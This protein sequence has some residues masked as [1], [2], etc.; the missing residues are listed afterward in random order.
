MLP[1]DV[2]RMPSFLCL[3]LKCERRS[4]VLRPADLL[5]AIDR[6]WARSWACAV[7]SSAPWTHVIGLETPSFD[8]V[9]TSMQCV[10][11]RR[12]SRASASPAS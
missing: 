2:G 8:A 6:G 3:S 11:A 1:G 5:G 7:M 10:W 12:Q 9:V 4:A